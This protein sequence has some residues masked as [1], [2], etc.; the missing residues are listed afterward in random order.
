MYQPSLVPGRP[1]PPAV[2]RPGRATTFELRAVMR[3]GEGD[4][5]WAPVDNDLL[6]TWD[7]VVEND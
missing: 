3:V 5:R 4:M 1:R 7:F 2:L 6:A